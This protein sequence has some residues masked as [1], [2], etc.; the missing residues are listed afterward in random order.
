MKAVGKIRLWKK[1]SQNCQMCGT[2]KASH[3]L[4]CAAVLTANQ[5]FRRHTPEQWINA[6]FLADAL[7][8]SILFIQKGIALSLPQ[9][10]LFSYT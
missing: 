7:S 4:L 8:E 1:V 6:A 10:S 3:K 9:R 2:F 5:R